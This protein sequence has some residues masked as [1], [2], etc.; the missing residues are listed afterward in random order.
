MSFTP[1]WLAL[2]EPA[3]R[4]ARDTA[5]L[6]RAARLAGPA[7]VILD[8]GCGTGATVRAM[9]AHLPPGVTWRLVDSDPALLRHAAA[10]AGPGAQTALLDIADPGALPLEGVTL[11]TASALLDLA[12]EAWLRRLAARLRVPFYAALSYD[13]RMRWT[14]PMPTDGDVT[15][16]FNA[17][18]RGDK[19]MGP[20]MG[21]EAVTRGAAVLEHAGFDVARGD[22]AWRL[23]PGDAALQ[24][25]LTDGIATAAEAAGCAGAAGWGRARRAAAD[26][27]G[28]E[29]GHGDLLAVPRNGAGE[30]AHA[31]G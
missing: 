27:T 13:G 1:E 18:Q 10:A 3:D 8:L 20:A 26:E 24:R 30:D 6:A 16:A 28:C 15:D 29:I 14:P 21:P 9:Q 17:H 19:G 23:G 5:L 4:A 25:A 2:R 12:G 22:S 7:P 31:S 11:V